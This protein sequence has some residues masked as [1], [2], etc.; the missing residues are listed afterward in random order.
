MKR[1]VIDSTICQGTAQCVV[2]ARSLIDIGADGVAR[3]EPGTE[4][5]DDA[6]AARLVYN[7]PTMA[8]EAIPIGTGDIATGSS[9]LA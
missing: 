4:V 1:V 8:I 5:V 6:L 9:P 3:V 7:C 2:V